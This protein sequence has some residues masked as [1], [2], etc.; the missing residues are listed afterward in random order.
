MVWTMIVRQSKPNVDLFL[1]VFENEIEKFYRGVDFKIPDERD[2][3]KIKGITIT[4]TC[5][6]PAK[7]LFFNMS[8]YNDKNCCPTCEIETERVNKN[9]IYPFFDSFTL[10]TTETTKNYAVQALENLKPVLGVKSPTRLSTLVY[11]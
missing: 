2:L 10:R 4:G 9:Q 6:L 1:S 3:V 11:I 8:L 5:D 7:A